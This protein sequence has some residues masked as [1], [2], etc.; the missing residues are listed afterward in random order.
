MNNDELAQALANLTGPKQSEFTIRVVIV[1]LGSGYVGTGLVGGI[2]FRGNVHPTRERA[3][4]DLMMQLTQG[5]NLDAKLG[6][7]LAASGATAESVDALVRSAI[8]TDGGS[9]RAR[10]LDTGLDLGDLPS[11]TRVRIIR[12][13]HNGITGVIRAGG[14]DSDGEY[15]IIN[16]GSEDAPLYYATPSQIEI[17]D[18]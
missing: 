1:R 3:A 12:G 15:A 4:Q 17:L 7:D 9:G 5:N 11:G 6:L 2:T 18:K 13:L 14:L 8:S 10:A 16:P